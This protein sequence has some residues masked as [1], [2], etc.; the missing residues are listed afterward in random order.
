[1][2][3]GVQCETQQAKLSQALDGL[4]ALPPG[5]RKQ[6]IDRLLADFT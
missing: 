2:A 6:A 5:K 3:L 4:A 1:L